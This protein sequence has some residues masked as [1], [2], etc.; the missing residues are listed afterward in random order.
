MRMF[1]NLLSHPKSG[2]CSEVAS[3]ALTTIDFDFITF[4]LET[5]NASPSSIC[6]IGIA[7]VKDG[8]VVN[9]LSELINPEETFDWGNIS[10]HGIDEDLV[11]GAM[12]FPDLVRKYG[13]LFQ[14][15]I[16]ISH[17]AFDRNAMVEASAKYDVKNPLSEWIDSTRVVRRTWPD[18]FGKRG[19]GL[20]NLAME[21]DFSFKH[22]DAGEDA[23]CTAWVMLK[24]LEQSG[25]SVNEWKDASRQVRRRPSKSIR[26]EP[27]PEGS[28]SDHIIVFTGK[29]E[30]SRQEAASIAANVGMTV[31]SGVTKK[32]TLVVVGEQDL[33]RLA[34]HEKSS[35][36]RKAE[37]CIARGQKLEIIGEKAFLN[38][39]S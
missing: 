27:N 4:D 26:V 17:S 18:R 15:N 35:K 22:H 21:F 9:V 23:K 5:A 39:V 16:A 1:K 3:T 20:S 10:I 33:S 2:L 29:L 12:L 8:V 24:A 19:Y 25:L 11:E 38:L 34:D 31:A 7:T 6:Q 14:N 36:H 13:P 37:E 28:H 30:I 32:T